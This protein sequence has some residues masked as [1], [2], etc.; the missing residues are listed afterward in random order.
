M[1]CLEI[2]TRCLLILNMLPNYTVAKK[3]KKSIIIRTQGQEK[4]LVSILLTIL[5]NGKK[6]S[7]LVLFKVNYTNKKL[8]EELKENQYVQKKLIFYK[9]NNKA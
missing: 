7:P 4:C 5:A 3:G 1:I 6:L 2:W 8:L 9:I